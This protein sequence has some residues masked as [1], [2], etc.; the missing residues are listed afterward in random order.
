MRRIDHGPGVATMREIGSR[1]AEIGQDRQ[2][3]LVYFEARLEPPLDVPGPGEGP[4]C[5]P[6]GYS[7]VDGGAEPNKAFAKPQTGSGGNDPG[8]ENNGEPA[9]DDDRR[10]KRRDED[11]DD[12]GA[13]APRFLGNF[14]IHALHL[15][16]KGC[17][18]IASGDPHDK[19]EMR[20]TLTTA[21]RRQ[22]IRARIPLIS[23]NENARSIS[24]RV[25]PSAPV[26]KVSAVALS[27]RAPRR[28]RSHRNGP[29]SSTVP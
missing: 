26:L 8:L 2:F 4:G 1:A 19:G 9:R 17:A 6:K 13:V 18:L 20:V 28:L 11:A 5:E 12:V 25:L 16:L 10:G 7:R 22:T 15:G 23:S 14:G 29:S 27:C 3:R 24:A 21:L